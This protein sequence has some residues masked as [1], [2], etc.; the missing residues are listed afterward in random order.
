MYWEMYQQARIAD[1]N[2]SATRA[3]TKAENLTYR[4]DRLEDQID[5]L[6]LVCQ[7]M[8]EL[9]SAKAANADQA[10]EK[11]V[12]EIDLRDGKLDGKMRRVQKECSNCRRPLHQRHR[13]CLYCG[14]ASDRET[15]FQK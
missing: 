14:H 7:A 8:W 10:L 15:V 4:I 1:A 5:S 11:K 9:L 13:R 2:R 6:S 12:R 3:Q